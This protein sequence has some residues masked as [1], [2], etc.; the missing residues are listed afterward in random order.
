VR[1]SQQVTAFA[2]DGARP[3]LRALALPGWVTIDGNVAPSRLR[4]GTRLRLA[5]LRA[6]AAGRRSMRVD[7]PLGLAAFHAE[8][9]CDL[10]PEERRRVAVGLA[11]TAGAAG[12]IVVA[13]PNESRGLCRE[14]WTLLRW[15]RDAVGV[16]VLYAADGTADLT[17]LADELVVIHGGRVHG[18]GESWD[19]LGRTLR[20]SFADGFAVESLLGA[21][22]DYLDEDGRWLR[23]VL[24]A[25]GQEVYLPFV[26]LSPGWRGRVAIR[27]DSVLALRERIPGPRGTNQIGGVVAAIGDLNGRRR[28]D[29]DLG[30]GELLRAAVEEDTVRGLELGIGS[31]II[32]AFEPAAVR[33]AGQAPHG[34]DT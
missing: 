24:D 3:F 10:G 17:D 28:V 30:R 7:E 25:G 20:G 2:G 11:V 22:V 29:V 13:A 1:T 26:R 9:T 5:R 14:T 23:V 34:S 4:V 6:A 16:P 32:C 8:R 15:V 33:W 21:A 27:P 19:L 18:P 12:L 31:E